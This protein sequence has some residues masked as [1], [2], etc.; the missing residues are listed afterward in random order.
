MSENLI[1]ILVLGILCLVLFGFLVYLMKIEDKRYKEGMELK[2]NFLKEVKRY[3]DVQ[4]SVK[5][6]IFKVNGNFNKH[7]D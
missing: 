2:N 1:S 6:G 3:N 4:Q 7:N 5:E